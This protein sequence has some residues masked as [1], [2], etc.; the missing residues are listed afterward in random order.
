MKVTE[1]EEANETICLFYNSSRKVVFSFSKG[2]E[3]FLVDENI[4]VSN[5]IIDNQ[6]LIYL[7]MGKGQSSEVE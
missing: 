5:M 7:T 1:P 6:N 2:F 3:C 4:T